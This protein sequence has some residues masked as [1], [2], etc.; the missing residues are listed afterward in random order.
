M[1]LLNVKQSSRRGD[2]PVSHP[3]ADQSEDHI[4]LDGDEF[5]I[6]WQFDIFLKPLNL[7]QG[8]Y[9]INRTPGSLVDPLRLRMLAGCLS[10]FRTA[11]VG[12]G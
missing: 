10:N 4:L 3:L 6:L 11:G 7:G 1:M 2:G 9:G 5:C 12:P 8:I